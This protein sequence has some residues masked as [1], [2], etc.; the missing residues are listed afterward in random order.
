M[1]DARKPHPEQREESAVVTHQ[2]TLFEQRRAVR[3]DCWTVSIYHARSRRRDGGLCW[4]PAR[5]EP[6]DR[7][8]FI[9]FLLRKWPG[10]QRGS[11][12]HKPVLD[13]WT[14]RPVPAA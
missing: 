9:R 11:L 10:L 3:T 14:R 2:E 12:H 1:I 6:G 7:F 4:Y 5:R 8:R 13:T